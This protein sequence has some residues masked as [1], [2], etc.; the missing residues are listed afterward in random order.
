MSKSPL[1]LSDITAVKANDN[2][3]MR[4]APMEQKPQRAGRIRKA[5]FIAALAGIG[6]AGLFFIG[7]LYID[8][9]ADRLEAQREAEQNYNCA[10]YGAAMNRFYGRD[11]CE[12]E[13]LHRE[14]LKP[15]H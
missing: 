5:L 11:V 10:H 13:A 6:L 15:T 3:A 8:L 14:L 4:I 1:Y 2:R 7:P 12:D 9:V